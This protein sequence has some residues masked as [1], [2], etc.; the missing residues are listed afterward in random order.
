[1]KQSAKAPNQREFGLA[2]SYSGL[3]PATRRALLHKVATAQADGRLP[4]LAAGVMRD[5][6]QA[7]FAGRGTVDGAAPTADTQYRI[8]SLTKMFVAVTVMRLRDE[9]RLRLNDPLDRHMP[10]A[11][12]EEATIGELRIGELLAHTAGLAS[13]SAGP[14]WE[15]T[16]GDLRP[17][18]SD[19]LGQNPSG[20]LL[21]G[22]SITPTSDSPSSVPLSPNCAANRGMR[23]YGTRSSIHWR[24]PARR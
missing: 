19:V 7:W 4:S 23:S 2:D 14:W 13:D 20:T 11:T 3:L 16:P 8:A 22:V 21:A 1:M 9:G 24:C 12:I 5:G 15:R 10:A 17:G 6:G 18:F